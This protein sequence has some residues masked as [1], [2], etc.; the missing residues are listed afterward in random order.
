MVDWDPKNAMGALRY[1]K[2]K[3]GTWTK[4]DH[5]PEWVKKASEEYFSEFVNKNGHRPYD[6]E[7][8]FVGDS[9]KYRVVFNNK[10]QMGRTIRTEYY[11]KMK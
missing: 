5:P 1:A 8:L 11:A 10:D 7:K 4:L 3:A 2:F 9:L 6:E